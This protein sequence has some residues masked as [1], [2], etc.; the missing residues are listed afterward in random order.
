MRVYN[1]PLE[2]SDVCQLAIG[3]GSMQATPLQIANVAATVVN[4]GTLYRPHI[5]EQIRSPRGRVLK[6]F[7]HEIIRNVDVTAESLKEV[8][9]GM[10]QVTMPWGT[11]YGFA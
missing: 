2:P 5:V 1:L 7:D 9:A 6:T 10:A 8:R 4:G 11:A 3:Q